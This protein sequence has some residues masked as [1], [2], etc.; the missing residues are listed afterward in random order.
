MAGVPNLAHAEFLCFL[1]GGSEDSPEVVPMDEMHVTPAGMGG[2]RQ[3]GF[4]QP[5][6][7]TRIVAR[8]GPRVSDGHMGSLCEA[9][10]SGSAA[11]AMRCGA[12]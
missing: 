2:V 5:A 7:C 3:S 6:R 4:I 1:G 10:I 11:A 12:E 9:G 8:L